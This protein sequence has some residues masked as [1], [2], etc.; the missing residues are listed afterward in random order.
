M[1]SLPLVGF[2]TLTSNPV[3]LLVAPRIRG[4]FQFVN[5]NPRSLRFHGRSTTLFSFLTPSLSFPSAH[6]RMFS[7]TRSPAR[8]FLMRMFGQH[9]ARRQR[10]MSHRAGG[11]LDSFIVGCPPIPA[12]KARVPPRLQ[13]RLL[14]PSPLRIRTWRITP[15]PDA[16]L[17]GKGALEAPSNNPSS[18]MFMIYSK[19]LKKLFPSGSLF[20][21][22]ENRRKSW[23][24]KLCHFSFCARLLRRLSSVSTAGSRKIPIFASAFFSET[25]G[26]VFL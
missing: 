23:E 26:V 5:E 18:P 2:R 20:I 14:P 16:P 21:F 25:D 17:L 4:F 13:K 19:E 24:K 11:Q 7:I 12:P 1:L 22:F 3:D 10:N 15:I 9:E 6:H 8:L